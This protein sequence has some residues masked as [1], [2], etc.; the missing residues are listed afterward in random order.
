[1][2]VS[3]ADKI[4]K[5]LKLSS[6]ALSF[7]ILGILTS[8]PEF[9]LGLTSVSQGDPEIFVGNLLGGIVVMFLFII[10]ILAIFGN[11]VKITSELDTKRMFLSLAV[12]LLPSIFMLDQRLSTVEGVIL[13]ISYVALLWMV[14]SKRGVLSD[15]AASALLKKS[16]SFVDIV[17]VMF[18]LALVFLFSH[19][20]V[21]KTIYFSELLNVTPFYISLFAFSLGTNLPELSLAL[22]SIIKNKK[23]VALGDY[24]GS[25]AVN[26]FLAGLLTLFAGGT[27]SAVNHF[28]VVFFFTALALLSFYFFA[29]SDR[30]LS[31]TEGIILI[32]FYALFI[33]FEIIA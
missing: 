17:R 6:F 32:S 27:V 2:I 21:Q 1:M 7:F 25:A 9:A 29:R 22:S 31:R 33:L 30:L 13:I 16:Y 12:I 23:D 4:S 5:K 14:Q 3:S 24:L 15:N 18:G 11:G 20:V 26:V 10:P 19:V 28:S 8:V